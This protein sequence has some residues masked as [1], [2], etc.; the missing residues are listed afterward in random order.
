MD[1][2]SLNF[3]DKPLTW[4]DIKRSEKP[5]N[6]KRALEVLTTTPEEIVSGKKPIIPSWETVKKVLNNDY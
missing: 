1:D 5:Y 2:D 4:N 3:N 6:W